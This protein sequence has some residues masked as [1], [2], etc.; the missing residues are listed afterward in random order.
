MYILDSGYPAV[1]ESA[2]LRDTRSMYAKTQNSTDSLYFF[3]MT[4]W[5]LSHAHPPPVFERCARTWR[6]PQPNL[7]SLALIGPSTHLTLGG[8]FGLNSDA[9]DD[10]YTLRDV[11]SRAKVFQK[12]FQLAPCLSLQNHS[13]SALIYH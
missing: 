8:H 2:E 10:G 4:L 12:C 1:T 9:N 3:T 11:G 5:Q 13:F 7:P 6:Y